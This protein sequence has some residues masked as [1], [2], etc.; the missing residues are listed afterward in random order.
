MKVG[1]DG[2]LLGA[3]TP[4]RPGD[5]R[6]LDIGTGTGVIALMMAQRTESAY[7]TGVDL[8]SVEEAKGNAQRSPW[9]DRVAL[10]QTAVQDFDPA[11]RFDLIVSNPPFFV[12]ALKC[13]DAGRTTARHAVSLPFKDLIHAVLR[14]MNPDGHFT[15]VLP[16]EEAERFRHDALL[17]LHAT[18]IV[19][20]HT[21]PRRAAKR[22]LM[23]FVAYDSTKPLPET[24]RTDLFIG[25]GEH[26]IYTEEYRRLTGDFYLKF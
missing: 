25:T 16:V 23:E 15:L 5:Q 26:E 4:L 6:I 18:Q 21:T 14:L 10:V 8:E 20:V 7:I 24:R 17:K 3:W 2:V 9:A 1:T 13:P 11:Q 22:R 12:D 19:D